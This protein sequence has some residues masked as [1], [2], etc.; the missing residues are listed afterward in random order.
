MISNGQMKRKRLMALKL[1]ASIHPSSTQQGHSI[2]R[3]IREQYPAANPTTSTNEP[4][5][6][7]DDDGPWDSD[8]DPED[9]SV[10]KEWIEL[11]VEELNGLTEL[12]GDG[13]AI[14]EQR[15]CEL[16][17]VGWERR[18]FAVSEEETKDLNWHKKFREKLK[19]HHKEY[20]EL[21]E[22]EARGKS[23]VEDRLYLLELVDR[24]YG[25]ELEDL[26]QFEEVEERGEAKQ[27][28]DKKQGQV[29]FPAIEKV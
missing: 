28:R 3:Q 19:R 13:G 4:G 22:N 18:G 14:N 24:N 26:D 12:Q 7:K 15:L 6:G 23:V 29:S 8:S 17:L 16:Q 21:V 25:G 27:S 11:E 20:K 10:R 9:A 5:T 1:Q 2:N